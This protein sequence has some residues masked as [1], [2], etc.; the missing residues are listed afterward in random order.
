ME[1]VIFSGSDQK[2][3]IGMAEVSLTISNHSRLLP[4]DYEE[5]TITR[6][7]FR[8]GES[9]YLINKAPVRLKDVNELF[10]GTGIGAEAYSIIE[11]GKIDLIISSRPEDRRF[12]FEEA[13]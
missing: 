2:E 10:M 9:E 11:Q 7:L 4:I 5:V 12:I 1:D 3:P 6:R 13:P 8:S